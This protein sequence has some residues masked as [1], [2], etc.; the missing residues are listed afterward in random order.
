MVVDLARVVRD[1]QRARGLAASPRAFAV[2]LLVRSLRRADA[3]GEAL[4]ARGVDD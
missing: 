3:I 4:A 2:P 1:A